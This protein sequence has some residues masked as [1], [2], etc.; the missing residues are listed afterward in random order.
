VQYRVTDNLRYFAKAAEIRWEIILDWDVEEIYK[1]S[2]R[3]DQMLKSQLEKWCEHVIGE[4][5]K[6]Y[7]DETTEGQDVLDAL[8]GEL[9][10][11]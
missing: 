2:P 9:D 6:I 7:Q 11:H 10:G 4:M 5:V 3:G 8:M 1:E